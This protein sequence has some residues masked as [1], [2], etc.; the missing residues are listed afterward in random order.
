MKRLNVCLINDSFPPNID[1]VSNAVYNYADI[2]SRKFGNVVVATPEYPGVEDNYPFEVLRFKSVDT[3]EAFGY[4]AGVPFDV[5]YLSNLYEKNIDIIHTHCPI[6]S[7]FLAR[8]VREST[9]KPIILTYHT[10]FDIDIRRSIDNK[11]LQEAAIKALVANIETVDEVWAVSKGAGENLKSLG[12]KGD[13]IVMPNGVDMEKYNATQKEIEQTKLKYNLPK[14]KPV[15]LFVGR[16][17]WYKGIRIILDALKQT[18]EHDI[19]FR[20]VFV[21]GG[22]EAEEIQ[23]YCTELGLDDKVLFLGPVYD[24]EELRSIYGCADMFLFPSTFDTNGIVVREAAANGLG[25]ILVKGSCAAEDT[26]DQENV[27]LIEENAD[28]LAEV[29]IHNGENVDFY[30]HIGKNA[31]QQLY[32]SWDEAVEKAYNRYLEVLDKYQYSPFNKLS[33][34]DPLFNMFGDASVS[35]SKVRDV[36]RALSNQQEEN[37]ALFK[38]EMEER[39]AK[40]RQSLDEFMKTVFQNPDIQDS[41]AVKSLMDFIDRYL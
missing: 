16:M 23:T 21:G 5:N 11:L 17:M 30:H 35:V 3:E 14:D 38:E 19:D 36:S 6:T 18:K 34:S 29:L 7:T 39:R 4:R 9:K 1:G 24:R 22:M 40:T 2:I 27:I 28:S 12:Y 13:Y 10:K 32:I 26:I 8:M 15:Y 31:Q 37:A 20:M 33:L 25:S 41:K